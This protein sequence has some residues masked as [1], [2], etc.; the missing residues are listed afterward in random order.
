MLLYSNC[1]YN[2]KHDCCT[3][4]TIAR[5]ISELLIA[6]MISSLLPRTTRQSLHS[7]S[8][9][10]SLHSQSL[11]VD[12]LKI[13]TNSC[14]REETC[15]IW[16]SWI[17]RWIE[18]FTVYILKLSSTESDVAFHNT[19]LEASSLARSMKIIQRLSQSSASYDIY[20]QSVY[21]CMHACMYQ[22]TY[23]CLHYEC[24]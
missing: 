11:V 24:V 6:M 16:I 2:N 12:I 13:P 9:R 14:K 18:H 7:Q 5:R 19:N 10:Q 3:L 21:V 23:A 4:P 22:C 17:F 8:P 15:I 1:I 20:M